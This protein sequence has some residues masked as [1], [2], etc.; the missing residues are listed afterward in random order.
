M[1]VTIVLYCVWVIAVNG[2]LPPSALFRQSGT[3]LRPLAAE[4]GPVVNVF[5]VLFVILGMGMAS[6]HYSLALMNQVRDWLPDERSTAVR[7]STRRAGALAGRLAA[8]GHA[9]FWLGAAPVVLIFGLGEWQ[10]VT[11]QASFAGPLGILGVLSLSVLSG[12]FPAL[13]LAASRQKGDYVPATVLR[14]LGHPVVLVGV[15][16]L[17][18]ASFFVHGLVIWEYP[19]QRLAALVVG[20][21]SVII[22]VVV[23]RRGAF[24]PRAVVELRVEPGPDEQSQA[25]VNVTARGRP[26]AAELRLEYRGGDG[27]VRASVGAP[28]PLSIPRSTHLELP[29]TSARQL[30]VWTHKV[31]ETGDSEALPAR[32]EVRCEDECRLLDL[33]EST[34]QAVVPVSGGPCEVNIRL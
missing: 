28:A 6:I 29:G 7:S 8:S 11:G 17:F 25:T 2:A 9:R 32:V 26:T 10:L 12:T 27:D 4:V 22:T 3:A 21:V 24:V 5:G 14:F 34:G 19:L 16:L 31:T 18:A 20:V 30:K 15:Y 33:G 13:L 1:G 23:V